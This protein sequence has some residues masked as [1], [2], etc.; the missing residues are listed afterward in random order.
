M[1]GQN[2]GGRAKRLRMGL[3]LAVVIGAHALDGGQAQAASIDASAAPGI[4]LA[5]LTSQQYPVFFKISAD[6]RTL[7]LGSIAL[8]MNCTSGGQFVLADGFGPV[9]ISPR[10]KLHATFSIPPTA[11]SSGATYSGTDSLT[12]H[13]GRRHTQLSGTWRLQV[14]YT[15]TNGMSD[16]CDSGPVRFT[17][18]G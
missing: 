5:G 2:R 1:N 7:T 16:R 14:N 8:S 18:T 10:G 17:A 12:A 9:R 15:F 6:A 11:G 4:V 13:L 3:A